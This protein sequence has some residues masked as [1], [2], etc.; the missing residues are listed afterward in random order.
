M[1]ISASD[2]KR[3]RVAGLRAADWFVRSQVRSVRPHWDANEGRYIYNLYLKSRNPVLGLSW[4][5]G[6]GIFVT[7][8]AWELTG[9]K[10]YRDSAVLAGEYIKTLQVYDS[11]DNPRRQYA[12][13]EEVP[14]SPC[15]SPRD[16]VEAALGYL[17]LY[18]ATGNG[19]YVRRAVDYATWFERNGWTPSGW[20]RGD[21]NLMDPAK[22]AG[23]GAF[24]QSVHLL[25]FRY[26]ALATKN[27]GWLRHVRPLADG[28]FRYVRSDGALAEEGAGGH[29]VRDGVVMNDDGTMVAML[30]AHRVMGDAKYLD[31][32]RRFGDWVVANIRPPFHALSGPPS[33][34]GTMIELSAATGDVRYRE[35]AAKILV[36]HVLPLQVNRK[37]DA[38]TDGAFRGE[39]E[40]VEY[41]GPKTA[42]PTDFITTRVTCYAAL[43]CLKL[44]G[45][46]GPYYGAG[47][48]ERKIT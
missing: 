38:L 23:P 16:S 4:T 6:R 48:W 17:F 27:D 1:T 45:I 43:A 22:N 25:F 42:K 21:V 15:A 7:L 19:D 40:P 18:R 33:L 44:A 35:W 28:V 14:N 29:H 8:A 36:D 37:G 34:C 31:A 10:E 11:P 32:C 39:D 26:L 30:A 9:R 46:V 47:G 24:Y 12:I 41:Y 2:I 13:R 5:Q 3:C 20:P